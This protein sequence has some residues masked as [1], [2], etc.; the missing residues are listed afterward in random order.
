MHCRYEKIAYLYP[1]NMLS[2]EERIRFEAHL[3]A[4]DACKTIVR[5]E[6]GMRGLYQESGFAEPPA[7]FESG[8][9]NKLN[10]AKNTYKPAGNIINRI[11][12]REIIPAAALLSAAM[13][14]MIFITPQKSDTQAK[15]TSSTNYASMYIPN[16]D[17]Y[18]ISDDD[19]V[20]YNGFLSAINK[21]N[22][23]IETKQGM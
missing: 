13:L 12:T 17:Q 20:S 21:A 2:Q 6:S 5:E 9:F 10:K 14:L 18:I 22:S 23:D 4:C 16:D 7:G 15:A 8:I 3:G 19:N 1:N 11:F